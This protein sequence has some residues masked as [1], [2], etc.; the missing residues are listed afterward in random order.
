MPN[1]SPNQA[2]AVLGV[3]TALLAPAPLATSA[4]LTAGKKAMRKP[5][6]AVFLIQ[7][8]REVVDC[9]AKKRYATHGCSLS[10]NV[11][12]VS[13]SNMPNK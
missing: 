4:K 9:K 11:V 3:R 2:Y 8:V 12:C 1:K 10:W 5:V 13:T 7:V 6:P